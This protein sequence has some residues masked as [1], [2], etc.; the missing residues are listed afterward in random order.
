MIELLTKI[1]NRQMKYFD[2]INRHITLMKIIIE[3]EIEGRLVRGGQH[4]SG[5]IISNIKTLMVQLVYKPRQEI[6]GVR[7][8]L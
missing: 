3:G 2:H 5:R 7:N 4:K 8:P 1:N 6:E